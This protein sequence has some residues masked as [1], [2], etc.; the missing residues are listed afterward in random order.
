MRVIK[1]ILFKR[2]SKVAI[3]LLLAMLLNACASR[4]E[5]AYFN[6]IS[7]TTTAQDKAVSDLK[8]QPGDMLSIQIVAS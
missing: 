8:F 6:D 5:I 7:K 2:F 3:L 1:R 4:K